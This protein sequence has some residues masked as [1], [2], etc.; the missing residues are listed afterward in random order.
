M[1]A[2]HAS[3]FSLWILPVVFGIIIIA[4]VVFFAGLS[5]SA[6]RRRDRER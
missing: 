4:G 1:T 6:R 3:T 2:P 5:R